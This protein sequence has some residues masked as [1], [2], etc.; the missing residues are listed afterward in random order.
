MLQMFRAAKTLG[1]IPDG[2]A[3]ACGTRR[4]IRNRQYHDSLKHCCV[5]LWRRD[6]SQATR[7]VE[8]ENSKWKRAGEH[9]RVAFL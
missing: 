2:L 6:S 4:E 3:F 7:A 8:C 5:R 9:R 1:G